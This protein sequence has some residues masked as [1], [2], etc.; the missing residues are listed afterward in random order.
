MSGAPLSGSRVKTLWTPGQTRSLRGYARRQA[1]FDGAA[2]HF[3]SANAVLMILKH[4]EI[5][6]G[7]V[8][9]VRGAGDSQ[10]RRDECQHAA[11]FTAG[12]DVT[13]CPI[14]NGKVNTTWT[15]L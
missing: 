12:Q 10:A 5:D 14:T 11:I 9:A 15:T 2:W 7:I 8:V 1:G 3:V 13:R 6:A 4:E